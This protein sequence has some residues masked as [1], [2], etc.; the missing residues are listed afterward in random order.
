MTT[1]YIRDNRGELREWSIYAE[2]DGLVIEHGLVEGVKQTKFEAIDYGKAARTQSEQIASRIQSRINKML[3]R[4]YVEDIQQAMDSKPVNRL[5]L[6][7]P[8]LA[9][10]IQDVYVSF[11]DTFVQRKYDGNRCIIANVDGEVIAYSRNGKPIT[12]IRHILSTINLE[13]GDAV[14]GELYCH[15][16]PLQTIVSWI[17]REQEDTKKIQ[18]VTYDYISSDP[19]VERLDYLTTIIGR[20]VT[21]APTIRVGS[22]EEVNGLFKHFRDE[23]YEGAIIRDGI[24]GYEDG[25]RSKSLLKMKEWYDDEFYVVDIHASK[26]GWAILECLMNNGKT[27]RVS[28]PGVIWEREE[29]LRKRL[30]YIGRYVTVEYAY[31][32]KDGIP[33]HPIAKCWRAK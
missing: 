7:K 2:D 23:G 20:N 28:A 14:D 1:L 33:F 8:M 29:V 30:A 11:R 9:Q 18:Y 26:D 19:F 22:M 12:S 4:G 13:P 6:F 27:F 17:K 16:V 32:T 3:D 31:M 5:G 15:G 25:K 24:L 21:V 10:K